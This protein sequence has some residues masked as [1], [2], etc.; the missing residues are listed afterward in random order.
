MVAVLGWWL[1]N[2]VNSRGVVMVTAREL[3]EEKQR[4]TDPRGAS[5]DA[6]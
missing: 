5:A 4:W 6:A 1:S 3:T 2:G